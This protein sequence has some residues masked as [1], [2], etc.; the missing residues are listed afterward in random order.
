[1][2][3]RKGFTLIELLV[4]ISIIA[5]LIGILLPALGAARRTA[6]RMKSNVNVRSIG[7]GLIMYGSTNNDALPNS[8]ADL[9]G[10][11]GTEAGAL[12]K[13]IQQ[14]IFDSITLNN[15]IDSNTLATGV[16][17][18]ATIKSDTDYWILS[19]AN[20]AY[21]NHNLSTVTF[22]A[23]KATDK[24]DPGKSL[25][26]TNGPWQGGV[27]WADG[28][29]TSQSTG[30]MDTKWPNTTTPNVNDYLFGGDATNAVIEMD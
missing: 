28:H 12:V 18:E 25:W 2:K 14:N 19:T 17:T 21:S 29:T 7:T 3:N 24:T 9:N 1:M 13:L 20:N 11:A 27:F 26:N 16:T 5:L 10:T 30:K 22:V 15:P 23:D 6:N 8:A 4:V